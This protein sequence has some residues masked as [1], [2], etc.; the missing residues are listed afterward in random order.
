MSQQKNKGYLSLYPQT[1]EGW[2]AYARITR[3]VQLLPHKTLQMTPVVVSC[4]LACACM[5]HL[6]DPPRPFIF[7]NLYLR[8]YLLQYPT[9]C[10]YVPYYV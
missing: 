3:I 8:M 5:R 1:P 6:V 9:S 4:S 10:M 2:L 7:A